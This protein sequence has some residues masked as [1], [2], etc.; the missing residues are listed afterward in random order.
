[1]ALVTPPSWLQAGTYPAVSD[2]LNAQ[3][4]WATTGIINT[5]SLA[6]TQSA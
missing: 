5:A 3:A 2:R 4:L 1:M 6:V